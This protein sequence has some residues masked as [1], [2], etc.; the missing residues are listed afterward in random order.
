MLSILEYSRRISWNNTSING[1]KDCP[2]FPK[3]KLVTEIINITD[4]NFLKL[5]FPSIRYNTQLV[6]SDPLISELPFPQP[7]ENLDGV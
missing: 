1:V 6:I 7:V 4:A 5:T 3:A 2:I